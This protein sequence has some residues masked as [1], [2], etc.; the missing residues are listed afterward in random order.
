M[1]TKGLWNICSVMACMILAGPLFILPSL[2]L[3]KGPNTEKADPD[4]I[5]NM[6]DNRAKQ[7]F[8]FNAHIIKTI[9]VTEQN[10]MYIRNTTTDINLKTDFVNRTYEVKSASGGLLSSSQLYANMHK[11]GPR[12]MMIDSFEKWVGESG[13]P[14]C[15]FTPKMAFSGLSLTGELIDGGKRYRIEGR[16]NATSQYPLIRATVDLSTSQFL[17]LEYYDESGAFLESYEFGCYSF[18]Q[19][20]YGGWLSIN[21]YYFPLAV[22]SLKIAAKNSISNETSYRNISIVVKKGGVR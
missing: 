7:V 18:L 3:A 21:N 4:A 19:N 14:R 6:L 20:W 15:I 11:P 2:V 10:G 22:C 9:Q 8:S 17:D 1:L 12:S 13:L 5:I 16:H